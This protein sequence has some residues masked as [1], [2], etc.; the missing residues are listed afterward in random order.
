M[1]VFIKKGSEFLSFMSVLVVVQYSCY[2]LIMLLFISLQKNMKKKV[3]KTHLECS[4]SFSDPLIFNSISSCHS[5]ISLLQSAKDALK[6]YMKIHYLSLASKPKADSHLMLE[7][8]SVLKPYDHLIADQI[9]CLVH[10]IT[11]LDLNL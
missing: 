8:K 11:Q 1:T 2:V 10:I 7:I 3:T 5:P 9:H 4:F 6:F